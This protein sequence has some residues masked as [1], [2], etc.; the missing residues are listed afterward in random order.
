MFAQAFNLSALPF[1]E[2]IRTDRVLNDERF[3]QAL[4]RLEYFANYG[5][6][7]LMSGLGARIA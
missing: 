6:A 5:L 4:D 1:E 7:A 2:H 3:S